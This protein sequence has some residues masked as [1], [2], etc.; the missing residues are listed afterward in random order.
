MTVKGQ[1]EIALSRSE[2]DGE[3][4]S[5][6]AEAA[7]GMTEFHFLHA[8]LA[9][10]TVVGALGEGVTACEV[11]LTVHAQER[12]ARFERAVHDASADITEITERILR[13]EEAINIF[14][15]FLADAADRKQPTVVFG[16][17]NE[18]GVLVLEKSEEGGIGIVLARSFHNRYVQYVDTEAQF[19]VTLS[20]RENVR[21]LK[22]ACPDVP[23]LGRSVVNEGRSDVSAPIAVTVIKEKTARHFDLHGTG[24]PGEDRLIVARVGTDGAC[25]PDLAVFVY[26]GAVLVF[27]GAEIRNRNAV[28]K[29]GCDAFYADISACKKG[30]VAVLEGAV[31]VGVREKGFFHGGEVICTVAH[32]VIDVEISRPQGDEPRRAR[33]KGFGNL[34]LFFMICAR[35]GKIGSVLSVYQRDRSRRLRQTENEARLAAHRFRFQLIG[36]EREELAEE[37]LCTSA[38]NIVAVFS[39]AL[40]T[41]LAFRKDRVQVSARVIDEILQKAHLSERDSHILVHG[42]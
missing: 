24:Y 1:P 41:I 12:A 29:A 23:L 6:A 16:I 19:S 14:F 7:V 15:R 32:S 21:V 38:R 8:V 39:D 10:N 25:E 22:R 11:E 26:D 4:T 42:K 30:N 5:P 33:G 9:V 20:V 17:V 37:A 27:D 2:L 31:A 40:V 35:I 36:G 13:F 34:D 18:V 3:D 28:I